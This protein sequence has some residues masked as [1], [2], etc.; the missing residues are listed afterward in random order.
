MSKTHLRGGGV[1]TRTKRKSVFQAEGLKKTIV[2]V[3]DEIRNLYCS[4][5]IPWVIGYSGGKDSS[6]VLQLIWYALSDLDPAK[7]TKVVHVISTDTLVENPIVA[8]WVSGSLSKMQMAADAAELPIKA[9]RLTPQIADSFWVN[10]IGRGYPAPRPKF[11]WCT[12][13]LK[14]SASNRFIRE[15]VQSFGEAIL[16]LGTRKAESSGRAARMKKYEKSTRDKLS[17]NAYLPNT[18]VYTPI[19]TWLDDDVWAYLMQTPNPWGHENKEL[20][21][22]YRGASPDGECPLVVETGTP[23]CGDSRFGCWVCT[24]VDEDKSMSAMILNDM[25][26][27]W[28]QPLLHLRNRLDYRRHGPEG[29][30]H[31][32]D[33]RRMSGSVQLYKNRP[34]PGPYKQEARED[35]LRELLDAQEWIRSNGPPHV[36]ELELIG[37][38]EL[39]EIRRIW[40]V[41]KHEIEDNLPGIYQAATGRPYPGRDI[42]EAPPFSREA[43]EILQ[44]TC[45]DD[46]IHYEL[47]RELLGIEHRYR[48]K[49]RRAGLLNEIE[50]AIRK[51]FYA[52]EE[53]AVEHARAKGR[54]RDTRKNEWWDAEYVKPRHADAPGATP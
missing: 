23:S 53:D 49:A 38:G 44:Q 41:D 1:A 19:A 35:W 33:F 17:T 8:L 21:A 20:L 37:L 4:D 52:N 25:D 6:A 43:L 29:D 40:I 54:G 10:L 51:G 46:R 3:A 31:L 27:E 7:R 39:E 48:T 36:R 16:V 2:A 22:L 42:D 13:R 5:G 34:I 12:D 50:K 26:K 11:R 24:L 9:H 18:L 28:M 32:R 47:V 30:R 45:G 15:M 14:I